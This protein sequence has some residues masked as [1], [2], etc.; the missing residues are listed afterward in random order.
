MAINEKES[1]GGFVT[2]L[3]TQVLYYF[4]PR[5]MGVLLALIIVCLFFSV[6]SRILAPRGIC[7]A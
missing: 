4:K 5:D 7:S 6:M 3:Q 2:R 1:D